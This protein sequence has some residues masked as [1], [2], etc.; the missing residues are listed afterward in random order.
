VVALQQMNRLATVEYVFSKII[1]ARD[2]LTWYKI[3]D[4][5]ILISVKATVKAGIDLSGLT[6]DDLAANGK[7]IEVSLPEPSIFQI[8]IK[9][10]DIRIPYQETGFFR[11][12]FEATEVN[13]ILKVGEQQILEAAQKTDIIQQAT[14]SAQRQVEILLRQLGYEQ[15]TIRTKSKTRNL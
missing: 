3:G 9:P 2:E 4:R 5:K 6:V 7:S 13:S 1:E 14:T 8:N 12:K 15:I 11:D 10:E